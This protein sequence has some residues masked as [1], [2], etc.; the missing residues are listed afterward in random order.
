MTHSPAART[1]R[2]QSVR[3][4]Q[5]IGTTKPSLVGRTT[6]G[7]RKALPER[8]PWCSMT[9]YSGRNR[10]PASNSTSGLNSRVAPRSAP[11]ER[12]V[13]AVS[14]MDT[15]ACSFVTDE[16]RRPLA[17]AS[18]NGFFVGL[19]ARRYAARSR[20]RG[21][22]TEQPLE[23]SEDL[24]RDLRLKASHR[25]QAEA[26]DRDDYERGHVVRVERGI[27]R[28]L[29]DGAADEVAQRPVPETVGLAENAPQVRVAGRA[30]DQLAH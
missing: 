24:V 29:R 8:R 21:W 19:L 27:D 23:L 1:L 3:S 12:R 13:E 15:F 16:G 6:T 28:P 30:Q 22:Q 10:V 17:A 2:Y 7:V 4:P 9:P 18:A 25:R 5:G 11:R 26:L 20:I 14:A